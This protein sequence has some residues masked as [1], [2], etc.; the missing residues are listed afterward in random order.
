MGL[1]NCRLDAKHFIFNLVVLVVSLADRLV[2]PM[3][4]PTNIGLDILK[5]SLY[6]R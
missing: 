2:T 4:S 1:K 3:T 5:S 6:K